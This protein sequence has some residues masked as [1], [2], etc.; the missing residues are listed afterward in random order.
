MSTCEAAH[1]LYSFIVMHVLHFLQGVSI[2][3]TIT[4]FLA[5]DYSA[6]TST[7]TYCEIVEG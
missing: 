7:G 1:A 6:Q 2:D 3:Q 5:L 4:T